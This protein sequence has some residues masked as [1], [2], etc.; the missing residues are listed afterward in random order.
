MKQKYLLLFLI[1]LTNFKINLS[2]EIF[3]LTTSLDNPQYRFLFHTFRGF[4]FNSIGK[5]S[6]KTKGSFLQ[7]KFN[8][9]S[10][11]PCNKTI[12][13]SLKIPDTIHRLRPGGNKIVQFFYARLTSFLS[14][15]TN[16]RCS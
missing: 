3:E 1:H 14:V 15:Q 10:E 4:I 8:D 5:T 12:G 11:F 2:E 7:E 13:K 9:E 16:I 6:V